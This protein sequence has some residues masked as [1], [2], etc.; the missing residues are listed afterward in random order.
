MT[1]FIERYL[2]SLSNDIVILDISNKGITSL[3]DLT[4]FEN[5]KILYCYGNNLTSLPTLPQNLEELS[6][7]YNELTSLPT[8]PQKLKKLSCFNN[9][10]TSLPTLPQ[11]LKD[12]S[13]SYN[14]LTSLPTLPQNIEEISCSY[15]QLTSLPTLPQN[16]RI[17]DCYYNKLTSLPTTLPQNLQ[18]LYCD[19]NQLAS[20]PTLPQNLEYFLYCYNP[21]YEIVNSDSFIKIKQN[22]VILNNFRYLYY[23]LKLKKKLKKLLWEKVREPKIKKIYNPMNLIK[24][25]G[26]EKSD[27]DYDYFN[28]VLENW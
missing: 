13:C 28:K 22:I 9:K 19:K 7:Y 26:N 6:C 24:I 20:L 16:L 10:L 14:E 17:L 21:I 23:C 8:L 12:L 25:L 3:P 4:R 11:K 1:T 27:E 5:L 2:N 15:N 18:Q